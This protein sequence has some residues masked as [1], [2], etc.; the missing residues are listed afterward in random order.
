M[1]R[2]LFTAL[3]LFLAFSC[4]KTDPGPP[5]AILFND[6]IQW[7]WELGEWYGGNSFYW[8]H[9][10]SSGVEDLGKLPGNWTKPDDFGNGNFHLRFEVID[11][12]TDSAFQLQLG[13]WQ[14]RDKDGGHSETVSPHQT[15]E[16]GKGAMIESDLG[17]PSTWWQLRPD[18]P[19]DFSRPG[20]FYMVGLALWKHSDP[21]CIPMGQGWNSSIA[22]PDAGQV[23][24]EFF[25]MKARVLVVAVAE[26]HTFSGCDN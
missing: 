18:A 3:A 11:Q 21:I 25:P 13:F 14:D 10:T 8:W 26:S 9:N 12:P 6:T 19:V 23:A 24:A 17:S 20:D 16:G 2:A 1:M 5:E 15:L 22:C 7:Q 4:D